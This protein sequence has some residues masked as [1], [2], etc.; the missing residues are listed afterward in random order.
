[1]NFTKKLPTKPGFYAW[2]TNDQ[3]EP[4]FYHLINMAKP[5]SY[6]S[7]GGEWCRL[8][9]ADEVEKAYREGWAEGYSW[10]QDGHP[11]CVNGDFE[12]SR[13]KRVMEGHEPS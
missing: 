2:R 10:N 6:A 11:D 9:P 1:M 12:K 4:Q 13:A 8:V 5:W 3:T 7:V